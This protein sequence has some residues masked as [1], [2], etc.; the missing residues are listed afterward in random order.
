MQT[1]KQPGSADWEDPD[2]APRLT[3][4]MLADADFF[5][6]NTSV[7]RG[8]GRPKSHAAKEQISVRLDQDVVARLRDAGP[9]WQSQINALL[10]RALGIDK[11]P[12]D[13]AA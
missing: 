12:S 1:K 3:R 10:R 7:T 2:D 9:G 11:E 4:T 8:R 13:R 6:G 5:E